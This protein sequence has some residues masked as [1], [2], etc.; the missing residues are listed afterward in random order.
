MSKMKELAI[1]QANAV[2]GFQEQVDAILSLTDALGDYEDDQYYEYDKA[3]REL[4]MSFLETYDVE[5]IFPW[6][7]GFNKVDF[8]ESGEL[9]VYKEVGH[10]TVFG[11]NLYV[12]PDLVQVCTGD[13]ATKVFKSTLKAFRKNHDEFIKSGEKIRKYISNTVHEMHI[14]SNEIRSL[15]R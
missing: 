9:D 14:I 5:T 2:K 3:V 13:Y 6:F 7:R 10:N 4:R 12:G 11:V 8:I 15:I 1:E